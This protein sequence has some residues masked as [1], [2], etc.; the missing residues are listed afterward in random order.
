MPEAPTTVGP[1]RITDTLRVGGASS[2]YRAVSTAS[3]Q[4]VAVKLLAAEVLANPA[5]VARFHGD[6]AAAARL[7]HPNVLKTLGTGQEGDH[8]YLVTEYFDGLPLEKVLAA[9]R[10]TV[11]Q[12]IAL[13]R[14]LCRG[15]EHAH[16]HGLAHLH[17][18]PRNV[19]VSRDLATV[20]IA[21]FGPSDSEALAGQAQSLSTGALSLGAFHYL[22][23]EQSPTPAQPAAGPVDARA[24]LYTAGLLLHQ[25]LTGRA[26]GGKFVLPSQLNPELPADC[27]ALVL[28]CLARDPRQRYADA[29]EL[30][31]DLARLE[32]TLRLRVLS[33]LRGISGKRLGCLGRGAAAGLLLALAA[34][35]AG[36]RTGQPEAP[37]GL[38]KLEKMRRGPDFARFW[39][40]SACGKHLNDETH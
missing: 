2:V 31:A 38:Q 3:G 17:L 36:C 21:D 40:A 9:G 30:L 4:T 19:L 32:E 6:A 8:L 26:P 34:A 25:M 10:L 14:G 27:D 1:Y 23:P 11:A 35:M 12:A 28:K 33:E 22:A 29:S 13:F 20:K 39:I 15:L 16:R 18:Q 37:G 5:A 24:D 7:P